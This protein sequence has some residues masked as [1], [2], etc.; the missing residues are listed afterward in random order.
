MIRASFRGGRPL[1]L[2]ESAEHRTGEGETGKQRAKEVY[3]VGYTSDGS[4]YPLGR[5]SF[6]SGGGR[7]IVTRDRLRLAEEIGHTVR[8]VVSRR[9]VFR[10]RWLVGGGGDEGLYE[11]GDGGADIR[12]GSVEVDAHVGVF[13]GEEEGGGV[14]GV[15]E[16]CFKGGEEGGGM[17]GE[18]VYEWII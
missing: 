15:F 11:G 9:G 12:D 8:H 4:W 7:G 13:I 6:S 18:G 17:E 1:V 14:E 2:G 16:C 10:V 5:G 3:R